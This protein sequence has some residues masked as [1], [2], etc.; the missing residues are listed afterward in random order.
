MRE[1]ERLCDRVAIMAKGHIVDSG[2]LPELAERHQQNDFEEL[3]YQLIIQS[4][5]PTTQLVGVSQ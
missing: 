5:T 4:E 3:F 2:T 1:V